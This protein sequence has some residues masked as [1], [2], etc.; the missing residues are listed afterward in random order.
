MSQLTSVRPQCRN[1]FAPELTF[2]MWTAARM[3]RKITFRCGVLW[4]SNFWSKVYWLTR[5]RQ[6][7]K[8]KPGWNKI[9]SV[10]CRGKLLEGG[11]WLM[12]KAKLCSHILYALVRLSIMVYLR[13]EALFTE[14]Q[15]AAHNVWTKFDFF[16]GCTLIRTWNEK[17]T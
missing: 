10:Q 14:L 3:R 6:G 12:L 15:H 2:C 4:E 8:F 1:V 17:G 9:G 13:A 11:A 7:L 16:A 5:K